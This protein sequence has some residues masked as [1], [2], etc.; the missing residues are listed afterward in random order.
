MVVVETQNS[1]GSSEPQGYGLVVPPV[2]VTGLVFICSRSTPTNVTRKVPSG[3]K[4]KKKM[5]HLPNYGSTGRTLSL[6]ECAF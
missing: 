5:D 4:K 6:G 3:K 2:V 1:H